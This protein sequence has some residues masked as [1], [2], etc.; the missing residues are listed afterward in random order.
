MPTADNPA[1]HPALTGWTGQPYQRRLAIVAIYGPTPTPADAT[2]LHLW[3]RAWAGGPVTIDATGATPLPTGW[4]ATVCRGIPFSQIRWLGL[5]P[6][7]RAAL[8]FIA[9]TGPRVD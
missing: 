6:A 4:L 1:L 3:I 2:A 8:A 9:L 5:A 7:D